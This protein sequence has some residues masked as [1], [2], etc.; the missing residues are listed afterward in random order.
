MSSPANPPSFSPA[1]IR[2]LRST[3]SRPKFAALLG[4]SPNTV[5]RWELPPE[6]PHNLTPSP[7]ARRGLA[8]LTEGGIPAPVVPGPVP[9]AQTEHH[10]IHWEGSVLERGA[11][12]HV[13][14]HVED[15]RYGEA[16]SA[17]AALEVRDLPPDTQAE[18]A[19]LHA[20]CALL[21]RGDAHAAL[22]ALAPWSTPDAHSG[23]SPHAS[24]L[25]CL[26]QGYALGWP[27]GRHHD[28]ERALTLLH[29]ARA[30][31]ARLDERGSVF[32]AELGM[33]MAHA[34]CNDAREARC[35]I[36]QALTYCVPGARTAWRTWREE[37]SG[38]VARLDQDY[39]RAIHEYGRVLPLAAT[40]D[41]R[42]AR[43]RA[44][45]FIAARLLEAGES[46]QAVLAAGRQAQALHAEVGSPFDH[47]ITPMLRGVGEAHLRL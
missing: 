30:V 9:A 11:L 39:R 24:A 41:D 26:W 47:S 13:Y 28:R 37:A 38:H 15:S 43:A 4:V 36:Q 45:A 20:R 42:Y 19:A 16:R 23:L 35:H 31:M 34:T 14:A 22:A 10:P 40:R 18:A 25:V 32:W 29:G 8:R 44:L 1:D 27:D 5:Y 3:M 33:G 6:S 7:T 17:L 12:A 21:G 2:R 46:A